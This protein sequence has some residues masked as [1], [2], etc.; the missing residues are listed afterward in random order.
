MVFK[1]NPSN[2]ITWQYSF[3]TRVTA[4]LYLWKLTVTDSISTICTAKHI[5]SGKVDL[6]TPAQCKWRS[7]TRKI[8]DNKQYHKQNDVTA[9]QTVTPT[10]TEEHKNAK[11]RPIHNR[12]EVKSHDH[13]HNGHYETDLKN[14]G[15]EQE[16][17]QIHWK[18]SCIFFKDHGEEHHQKMI[19][20]Q[21][22]SSLIPAWK[23]VA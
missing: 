11:T 12:I 5:A 22:T 9:P 8:L 4:W 20:S 7:N 18:K 6:H 2:R 17:L 1:Y 21:I 13:G 19:T 15:I 3:F 14:T 16:L 10:S 23:T